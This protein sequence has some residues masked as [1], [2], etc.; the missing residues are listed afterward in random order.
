MSGFHVVSDDDLD[1]Y[2]AALIASETAPVTPQARHDADVQAEAQRLRVREQAAQIVR[3]ERA[4]ALGAHM[5]R[6]VPLP[7]FLAVADE[8]AAYRVAG[9]WPVGGRVVLAA[10]YKAGKT[11]LRDN[12]V[13]CLVDGL[14]FLGRYDVEPF[15]G[16]VVLIDNELDPRMLRRWL[17]EQGVVAQDRVAVVP[18]R[19][20]V[21]TFDLL[22]P[23]VRSQ[24][25]QMLRA[26]RAAVVVLDCLRPVLDALG[27]SEDKDAGRFLVAFD[28]LLAE[29]G[30]S[31]ALV[32]HHMGHAGE[33][34]RGDTRLRDWPD[35]EWRL[36]RERR[37]DGEQEANAR[38]Y[39][40][41]YG[42]D[43]EQPEGLVEY[44][45]A[46]RHLSLTGGSRRDT[47]ADQLVP[48]V[49]A[50]LGENPGASQRAVEKRLH[51]EGGHP[52]QD[53]RKALKRAV[54]LGQVDTA[55]G[56][57]NAVLHFLR[58]SDN[59]SAPSAPG[60]R[61][62]TVDECAS[63]PIE[64]ALTHSVGEEVRYGALKANGN[65]A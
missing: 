38:R 25:A 40:T 5:P 33:R 11:T 39:F 31:E 44:D 10:Q 16:N 14:P 45:S 64:G 46:T 24:W 22:D 54:A 3:Q 51:E 17:R 47:A 48:D 9:L 63:A 37:E 61:Q 26:Q 50:Y 29:S 43:V 59:Q 57:R 20:R 15:D 30:A 18:L 53:V 35:V 52:R 55:E 1:D 60:V 21:A 65:A 7:E 19:G 34:S 56:P 2:M 6:P 13:R 12:V 23:T 62:R 58:P 8:P 28:A 41:A 42:R 4:S 49:L 32:V 36:V 27:L